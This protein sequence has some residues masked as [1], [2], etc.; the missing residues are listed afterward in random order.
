MTTLL[1]S[2]SEIAWTLTPGER[3]RRVELHDRYGGS[4]QG[5]IC[6]SKVTHNVIVFTDP[7][8]GP[9]YGYVDSWAVDDVFVYTGEGQS[10]DQEMDHGN[11][12]LLEHRQDRRAIRLFEG[13]RGTVT[14][15]GEFAV[16]AD[17]PYVVARAGQLGVTELRDVFRFRLVP[18]REG[19]MP[20][21][22]PTATGVA[23]RPAD[24]NVDV[25]TRVPRL[26]PD[27]DAY[28]D[29]LSMHRRLQNHL[30]ALAAGASHEVLSPSP[31]DPEFDVAWRGVDGTVTV[32]EVKS[33]HEAN[34]VKQLRLGVGQVLD[35]ADALRRRGLEVTA[36]LYVPRAPSDDRW[37]D[38]TKSVGVELHWPAY[39]VA[40]DL[41]Q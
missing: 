22:P 19:G 40:V 13:S 29:G 31:T 41:S 37:L 24:E 7:K 18:V 21:V 27:P 5:G 8:T 2:E 10:G 30:A 39:E 28:G 33:L 3:I 23:Y 15:V 16:D 6:P 32:V 38:I 26:P 20:A 35:Y 11:K 25:Q 9:R 4:R 17:E 36:V 14:Y 1:S 34:E 12:A